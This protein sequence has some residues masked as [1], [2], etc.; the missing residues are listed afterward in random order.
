MSLLQRLNLL[1]RSNL[2]DISSGVRQ[3]DWTSAIGEMERSVRETRR[4]LALMRQSDR[5]LVEA[6]REARQH[7]ETWEERAL[8]ALRRGQEDLAREALVQKN[9]AA[10]QAESLREELEEHR[11]RTRDLERALEALEFKVEGA[12]ER[13]RA[14][15]NPTGTPPAPRPP[16][17]AP[18]QAGGSWSRVDA[19]RLE[20]ELS[21]MDVPSAEFARMEDRIA[22]FEAEAQAMQELA[23]IAPGGSG[24]GRRAELERLFRELESRERAPRTSESPPPPSGDDSLAD[25]KKKFQ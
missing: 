2:P 20:Q 3:D 15:L 14:L 4:H 16:Q 10:R 22:A 9:R 1:I 8:L 24:G 6:V 25:L 7:V 21:E 17:S 11:A 18:E 13:R 12:Q 5:R 19:T 23:D